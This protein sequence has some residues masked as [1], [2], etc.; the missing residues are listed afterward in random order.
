MLY[1]DYIFLIYLFNT[2]LFVSNNHFQFNIYVRSW[3]K[4]LILILETEIFLINTA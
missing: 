2:M 4:H 3:F 1:R